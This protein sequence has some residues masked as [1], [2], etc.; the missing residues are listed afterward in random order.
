[1]SPKRTKGIHEA[2]KSNQI[3]CS[4]QNF[5][6]GKLSSNNISFF[7]IEVIPN[8][9]LP[10]FDFQVIPNSS[11]PLFDFQVTRVR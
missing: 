3:T 11:L 7:L 1:M 6:N 10:L 5:W 2:K 4:F 8:S 9:S